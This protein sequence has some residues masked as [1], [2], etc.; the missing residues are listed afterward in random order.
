MCPTEVTCTLLGTVRSALVNYVNNT[1]GAVVTVYC[2]GELRML[3]GTT[4][5]EVRC[6]Q[7]AEWS[8][9]VEELH[10][11]GRQIYS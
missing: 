1:Y 4:E 3:D 5:A 2:T 7:S 10:C 9:S 8:K 6:M 11:E